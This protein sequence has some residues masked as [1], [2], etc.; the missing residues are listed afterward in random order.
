MLLPGLERALDDPGTMEFVAHQVGIDGAFLQDVFVFQRLIGQLVVVVRNID[1]LLANQFPVI[2]V[3]RAVIAVVL[4]GHPHA[5]GAIADVVIR[6]IR[7]AAHTTGTGVVDPGRTRFLDL[8]HRFAHQV[9]RALQRGRFE[10]VAQEGKQVVVHTAIH[11]LVEHAVLAETDLVELAAATY[12][13]PVIGPLEA[14]AQVANQVVPDCF[15]TILRDRERYVRAIEVAQTETLQLDLSGLSLGFGGDFSRQCG[16][17]PGLVD[18]HLEVV[19]LLQQSQGAGRQLVF[20]LIG[21]GRG[22]HHLRLVLRERINVALL[23]TPACRRSRQAALPGWNAAIGIAGLL[24]ANRSEVVTKARSLCVGQFGESVVPA[25]QQCDGN[26]Q[27]TRGVASLYC[28]HAL[29]L[30]RTCSCNSSSSSPGH[31][32]GRTWRRCCTSHS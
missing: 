17:A 7:G 29:F 20:V 9:D 16:G 2:T 21:I 27:G 32:T 11:V 26:S 12:R 15:L 1:C 4:V 31:A 5:L 25:K 13:E 3:G 30:I 14:T 28:F 22:D 8:V 10:E 23:R 24:G 19:I 6:Q 18:R